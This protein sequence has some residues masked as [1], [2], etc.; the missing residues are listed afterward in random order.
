[1]ALYFKKPYTF[2]TENSKVRKEERKQR[3]FAYYENQGSHILSGYKAFVGDLMM[4]DRARTYYKKKFNQRKLRWIKKTSKFKIKDNFDDKDYFNIFVSSESGDDDEYGE[5]E[6]EVKPDP[7]YIEYLPDDESE[8]YEEYEYESEESVVEPYEVDNTIYTASDFDYDSESIDQSSDSDPKYIDESDP[9]DIEY[10]DLEHKNVKFKVWD[11]TQIANYNEWLDKTR[12]WEHDYRDETEL[13]TL[14][15]NYDEDDENY[16]RNV[17]SHYSEYLFEKRCTVLLILNS[18]FNVD[19]RVRYSI[20]DKN[21]MKVFKYR[22]LNQ[23]KLKFNSLYLKIEKLYI[24]REL[25]LNIHYFNFYDFVFNKFN[26]AKIYRIVYNF[27]FDYKL[28][29]HFKYSNYLKYV[30][31]T[32]FYTLDEIKMYI[33]ILLDKK[34][35]STKIEFYNLLLAYFYYSCSILKL[36]KIDFLDD[37]INYDIEFYKGFD[38]NLGFKLNLEN[39]C[40]E[41]GFFFENEEIKLFKYNSNEIKKF[42]KREFD[43]ILLN[44]LIYDILNQFIFDQEDFFN[45]F[46]AL[47]FYLKL[48]D[49]KNLKIMF[50]YILTCINNIEFFNLVTKN[51]ILNLKNFLEIIYN[52]KL[53]IK[54]FLIYE[55]E[56]NVKKKYIFPERFGNYLID[57]NP[58]VMQNIKVNSL[59]LFNSNDL[60]D[61]YFYLEELYPIFDYTKKEE[62]WQLFT[63]YN[64]IEDDLISNSEDFIDD[65][66][67]KKDR[68]FDPE[69]STDPEYLSE[70]EFDIEDNNTLYLK[71]T[72][73]V[74]EK[75]IEPDEIH[76][77]LRYL[78]NMKNLKYS[79]IISEL[80]YSFNFNYNIQYILD[81]VISEIQYIRELNNLKDLLDYFVTYLTWINNDVIINKD[82][83]IFIYLENLINNVKNNDLYELYKLNFLKLRNFKRINLNIEVKK[84]QTVSFIYEYEYYKTMNELSIF[85]FYSS[86]PLIELIYLNLKKLH[87]IFPYNE[88]AEVIECVFDGNFQITYEII[89]FLEEHLIKNFEYC[90]NLDIYNFIDDF[91]DLFKFLV[92]PFIL[93]SYEDLSEM[94]I[95]NLLTFFPYMKY[96]KF[97]QI[98]FW[99]RFDKF[100]LEKKTLYNDSF[101]DF[102]SEVD[103]Y[104][105]KKK[106]KVVKKNYLKEL[107]INPLSMFGQVSETFK[108]RRKKHKMF[109]MK[110][111]EEDDKNEVDLTIQEVEDLDKEEYLEDEDKIAYENEKIANQERIKRITDSV[112]DEYDEEEDEL[113]IARAER[114]KLD[115]KYV[116]IYYNNQEKFINFFK[117]YKL[118]YDLN[119]E[120]EEFEIVDYYADYKVIDHKGFKNFKN[121][122]IDVIKF[123]IIEYEE[124]ITNKEEDDDEIEN[125]S[126]SE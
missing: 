14:I 56:D 100:D 51:N 111:E 3:L 25:N 22:L 91:I 12:Q 28:N 32:K 9:G 36:F 37:L 8:E 107:Q 68:Y 71:Y 63:N 104:K 122:I 40:L 82:N 11:E 24:Y 41:V 75:F 20:F 59:I 53:N 84:V 19:T 58:N 23:L 43:D 27:A 115:F 95:N 79:L 123:E 83:R 124:D 33:Q 92:H 17:Q 52:K 108:L 113:F 21:F 34:F 39:F 76:E 126:D 116:I 110:G 125:M 101:L 54:N 47:Y 118:N 72:D 112:S 42:Y 1:M 99:Y 50:N 13:K 10:I 78:N 61:S 5:E 35:I 45:H 80:I 30:I 69:G 46:E 67:I 6:E 121:S 29:K 109:D 4:R 120:F 62:Y 77:Y 31:N 105:L 96:V 70:A 57:I 55:I 81:K 15:Y 87:K 86:K 49:F 114:A 48:L 64:F 89:E 103:L 119:V 16:N 65:D 66:E 117:F 74:F 102:N 73:K 85:K 106:N 93:Y 7:N 38:C 26:L 97:L 44:E 2:Y 90:K 88:L 98:N 60:N 18:Q 94:N